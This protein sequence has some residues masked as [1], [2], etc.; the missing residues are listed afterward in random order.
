MNPVGKETQKTIPEP[1][2]KKG[3]TSKQREILEKTMER[4]DAA[5][6]KLARM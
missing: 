3:L 2:V 1:D 6:K 4:H 5:F